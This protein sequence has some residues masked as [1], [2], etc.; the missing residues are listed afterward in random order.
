MRHRL[1]STLSTLLLAVSGL[2]LLGVAAAPSASAAT[3]VIPVPTSSAGLGRIVTAP[4]GN[5]WFIERE[6][7]KLARMTPSGQISEIA[8]FAEFDSSD[9]KD[10]A[11]AP[12]GTVW[13]LYN[14]G[15][16]VAGVNDAGQAVRG[17]YNIGVYGRQIRIA[18]D[19]TPWI[20]ASDAGDDFVVRIVGDSA[21]ISANSPSCGDSLGRAA[22]GTMWCRSD[23]GLTRLNAD[24]SGGVAYP[25]NNY[26]AYPYAIAAGPVG[27]IWFGRYFDGTI[28]TSPDD[29]E[30][31]YLNAATGQ[32]VA[33]NTGSRTAPADLVQGPDGNMWFTSIGAAKGIG[34][35]SPNGTN[36]VLTQPGGYE[37]RSLT[38][39][40]DGF[41]YATDAANNVVLKISPGDINATNVDPGA[42]SVLTTGGGGGAGAG[43]GEVKVGKKP[44]AVTKGRVPLRLACPKDAAAPCV[45]QA[46]LTTNAKKK[47][48]PIST[49]VGYKVKPGK[50]GT[51]KLKLTGKG[52]KA[53][54]KGKATKVRLELYA[55]GGKQ[56][57]VVT[58]LKVRR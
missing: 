16:Y 5:L 18:T 1:V 3:Q 29:G 4:N 19:G 14:S 49:K 21:P 9:A 20:T 53:L 40:T 35:I 24:A 50:K 58:V 41:I 45:G 10:V 33:Y 27:S 42:G 15:R 32:V 48:K 30:V 55:K 13:V 28:F 23:S 37:P 51:L 6:A 25:A 12:D 46:R 36:G 39:G 8:L 7:N 34:R 52:L 47:P 44:V 22:D 2:A 54:K 26:A 57:L 11:V 56:P 31:G 43:L 17:P 38:F